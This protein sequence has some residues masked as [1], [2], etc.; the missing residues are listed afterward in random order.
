MLRC[1]PTRIVLK[2]GDM[3]EYEFKRSDWVAEKSAI[4]GRHGRISA[5]G[6]KKE[7]ADT[8]D[9]MN[10]ARLQTRRDRLGVTG[11]A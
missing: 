5:G 10:A 2:Q 4:E 9:L 1:R 7:A 3:Q 11:N 6:E 8:I